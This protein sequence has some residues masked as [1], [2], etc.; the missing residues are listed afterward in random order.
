M[1]SFHRPGESQAV[2]FLADRLDR[3]HD[4]NCMV[5]DERAA[6]ECPSGYLI[7]LSLLPNFHLTPPDFFW[8]PGI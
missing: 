2:V 8:F 3:A 4:L 6:G 1:L 7:N 5:N